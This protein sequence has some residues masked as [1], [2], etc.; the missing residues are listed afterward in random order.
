LF[1]SL[2]DDRS[3]KRHCGRRMVSELVDRRSGSAMQWPSQWDIV[4]GV[5]YGQD[6]GRPIL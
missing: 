3:R 4:A 2:Y 1:F 6:R 5:G